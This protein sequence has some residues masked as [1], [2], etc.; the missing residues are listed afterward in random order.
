MQKLDLNFL[1][2]PGKKEK[3]LDYSVQALLKVT[4]LLN[5]TIDSQVVV[6]NLLIIQ[7]LKVNIFGFY[8]FRYSLMLN[9]VV[10]FIFN[11]AN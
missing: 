10:I 8:I 11:I 4:V 6:N 7:Q 3:F 1:K 2:K 9:L 5:P